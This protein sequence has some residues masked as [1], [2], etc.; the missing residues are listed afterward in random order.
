MLAGFEWHGEKD[1]ANQQKHGVG[2]R[3]AV[4]AFRDDFGLLIPD[5]DGFG[6]EDR[7]ILIGMSEK[8][9]ILV[10][11][12]CERKA[13]EIVRIISARKAMRAERRQYEEKLP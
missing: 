8:L 7:F 9:R 13:G 5:P 12:H 6:D 4:S 1:R 2:F 10:V 11:C 3:E